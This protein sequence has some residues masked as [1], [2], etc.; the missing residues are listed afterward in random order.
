M[1]T[2]FDADTLIAQAQDAAGLG[3]L[4]PAF[5]LDGLYPL[6]ETYDRHVIDDNGRGRC[7]ARVLGLLTTRLKIQAAFNRHREIRDGKI[8]RPMVLTGLPRSGTSAL[9]NLLAMEP[10]TRALLQW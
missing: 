8:S 7:R 3:D 5:L 2:I 4:G 6:L 10:N 9:F 1:S